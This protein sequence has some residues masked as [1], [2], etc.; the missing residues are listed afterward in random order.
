MLGR[1]YSP[2]FLQGTRPRFASDTLMS[3]RAIPSS[4]AG[5]RRHP[6]SSLVP[7]GDPPSLRFGTLMSLQEG[8]APPACGLQTAR[9]RR[10]SPSFL[11]GHPSSLRFGHPDVT[12]GDTVFPRWDTEAPAL[13]HRSYRG[14]G[15]R[16]FPPRLALLGMRIRRR[17]HSSFAPTGNPPSQSS[18]TLM[19]LQESTAPPA[20]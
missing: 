4:R 13:F 11:Q 17:P 7:T 3:L 15:C 2:S 16:I 18:G 8:T 6:H 14:S 19:S 10:H 1:R 12:T 20:P 5:I 9:G